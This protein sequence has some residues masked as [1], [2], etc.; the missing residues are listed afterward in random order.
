MHTSSFTQDLSLRITPIPKLSVLLKGEHYRNT[1]T[2]NRKRDFFLADAVI[3]YKLS[4]Q[5]DLELSATNLLDEREY[6]YTTFTSEAS[7]VSRSYRIRPRNLLLTA[8]FMF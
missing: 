8:R 1:E 7:T 6:A 2:D 4:R 5:C 3:S